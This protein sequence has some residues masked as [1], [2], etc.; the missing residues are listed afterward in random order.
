MTDD[1]VLH[2]LRRQMA[3]ARADLAA[4]LAG[5]RERF[6]YRLERGRVVFEAETRARHRAARERLSSFLA[7]T[8]PAVVLTAPVIY[9]L[10]VPLA[11]LD[12]AV[13]VYQAVCFPVYGMARVRRGDHVF[14]DRHQLG[15]LNGL[16]K[17]NCVYCGYANGVLSFAREVAA[18]TEQYWCPIRHSRPV[19]DP[20]HLYPGFPAFGD[21]DGF[22]TR[23]G[24]LRRALARE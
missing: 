24:D 16:Q 13:T 12:L 19:P 20:H 15:Y 14:L 23:L 3:E 7:R 2:R 1:S 17:L 10:I 21:A 6:R 18:R 5:Q 8:R 22:R 4:D 9:G 11:L